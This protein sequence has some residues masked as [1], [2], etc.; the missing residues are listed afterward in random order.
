MTSQVVGSIAPKIAAADIARTRRGERVFD[1]AYE[2]AW[3]AQKLYRSGL[4][5]RDPAMWEDAIAMASDA[6]A[7]NPKCGVAYLV[8]SEIYS[9]QSLWR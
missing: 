9:M 2:L 4:Q 1:E 3:R 6:V 7:K 5:H 8:I